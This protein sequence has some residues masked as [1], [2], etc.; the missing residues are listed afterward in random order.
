VAERGKSKETREKVSCLKSAG[1]KDETDLYKK[2]SS[3][4][5]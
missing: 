5:T 1:A 2:W 3:T 4:G